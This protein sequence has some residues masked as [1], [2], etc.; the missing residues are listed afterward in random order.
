MKQATPTPSDRPLGP[1]E[2]RPPPPEISD[3]GTVRLGSGCITAGFPARR[4][5]NSVF[6][7]DGGISGDIRFQGLSLGPGV[8]FWADCPHAAGSVNPAPEEG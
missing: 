2:L 8:V 3:P 7:L 4:A 1:A 6:P 5:M